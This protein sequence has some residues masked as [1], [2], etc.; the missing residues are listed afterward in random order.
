MSSQLIYSLPIVQAAGVANAAAAALN[1]LHGTS[2][3]PIDVYIA[4]KITSNH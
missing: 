2:G 1:L 3:T 4:S